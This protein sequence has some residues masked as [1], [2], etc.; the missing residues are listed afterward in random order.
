MQVTC[1]SADYSHVSAAPSLIG[2]AL[3][4]SERRVEQR[5]LYILNRMHAESTP[6]SYK[7]EIHDL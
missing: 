2:A 3:R 7:E 6:T 4:A 5:G 1:A